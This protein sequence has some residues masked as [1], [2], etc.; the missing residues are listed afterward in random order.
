MGVWSLGFGALMGYIRRCRD[1]VVV[2]SVVLV[3]VVRVE[4]TGIRVIIVV[5]I[6]RCSNA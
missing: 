4:L 2:L 3:A 5:A 6:I 1:A